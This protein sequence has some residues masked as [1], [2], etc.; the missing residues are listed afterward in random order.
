MNDTTDFLQYFL[1]DAT[2]MIIGLNVLVKTGSPRKDNINYYFLE[3][4]SYI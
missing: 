3:C 2:K 4:K 1:M